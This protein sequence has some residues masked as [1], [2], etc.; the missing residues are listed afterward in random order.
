MEA[1]QGSEEWI[2][3]RLGKIT[4]SVIHKI[5]NDKSTKTKGILANSLAFERL[6]GKR[7]KSLVTDAMKRGLAIEPDA[8]E[9]YEHHTKNKVHLSGFISHP[10]IQNAGA[11]PDGLIG[12]EGLIEIKCLNVKN[13]NAIVSSKK[14]P[15]NYYYQIQFQLACCERNWADFVAY[16]PDAESSLFIQ[17]VSPNE[18]VIEALHSK[19]KLFLL[20]VNDIYF[21]KKSTLDDAYRYIS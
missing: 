5:W 6:T 21:K 20:T 4:A 1:K 8:R 19:V 10:N 7:V 17:R 2:N 3:E 14:I 15:K 18:K 16:N 12:S 11:S 13:H 9:A